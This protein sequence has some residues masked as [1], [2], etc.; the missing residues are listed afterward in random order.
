MSDR[1]PGLLL[2]NEE[3]EDQV[4]E[5]GAVTLILRGGEQIII[6]D[7]QQVGNLI[8]R[9][10]YFAALLQSGMS[11]TLTRTIPL[12][13][14]DPRAIRCFCDFLETNNVATWDNFDSWENDGFWIEEAFDYLQVCDKNDQQQ[15]KGSSSS[16]NNNN[17]EL[18]LSAIRILRNPDSIQ[19]ECL[20]R[21]WIDETGAVCSLPMGKKKGAWRFWVCYL[22]CLKILPLAQERIDQLEFTDKLNSVEGADGPVVL[23]RELVGYNLIEREG[24]GSAYWRP[25]YTVAMVRIWLKG[26][27]RS[28]V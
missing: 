4:V 12:G 26:M 3:E 7:A 19:E 5:Q 13:H 8:Q 21:G 23:R 9:S 25:P 16:N 17:E 22:L 28:V 6:Q 11:E 15:Q 10:R 18:T 2:H 27:P 20:A 1:A 14:L 24:D